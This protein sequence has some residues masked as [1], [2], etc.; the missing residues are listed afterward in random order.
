MEEAF[1]VTVISTI[2]FFLY[3]EEIF[4]EVLSLLMN[5]KGGYEFR[6]KGATISDILYLFVQGNLIFI[7]GEVREF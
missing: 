5:G 3:E 1:G 6:L 7:R 4:V 2:Y